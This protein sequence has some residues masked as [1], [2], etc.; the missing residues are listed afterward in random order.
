MGE[1]ALRDR[2]AVITGAG[3][4]IGRALALGFAEEGCSVACA[5]RTA[6]EIEDVARAAIARG[7]PR[8][9]AVTTDVA[10]LASV[11]ALFDQAAEQLGGVD[12]AIINAGISPEPSTVANSAPGAWRETIEVNLLLSDRTTR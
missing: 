2:I 3:R 1:L 5:A 8:A 11:E 4:G 7:A 6:S 12:I 9:I 10:D